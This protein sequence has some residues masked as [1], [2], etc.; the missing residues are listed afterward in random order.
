MNRVSVLAAGMDIDQIIK[1][2]MGG[3]CMDKHH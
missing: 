1:D 3:V 2:M